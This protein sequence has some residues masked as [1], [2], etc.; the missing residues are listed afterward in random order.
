MIHVFFMNLQCFSIF[1]VIFSLFLDELDM[2]DTPSVV[3]VI[4]FAFGVSE[5][6]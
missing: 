1:S 5:I 2:L 6:N 4:S 3:Y